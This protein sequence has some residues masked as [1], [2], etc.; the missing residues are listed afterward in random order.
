MIHKKARQM[1]AK[2]RENGMVLRHRGKIT[3]SI[4]TIAERQ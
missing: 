4:N 2:E 1:A 3:A